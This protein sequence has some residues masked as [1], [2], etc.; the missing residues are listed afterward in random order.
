MYKNSPTTAENIEVRKK[1]ILKIDFKNSKFL[2]QRL[3]EPV[4]ITKHNINDIS[5][6]SIG[7]E[8]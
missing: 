2:D 1:E 6:I 7:K 3:L 4:H 8:F 5:Q